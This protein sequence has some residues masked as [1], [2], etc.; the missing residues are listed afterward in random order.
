MFNALLL[1]PCVN[2]TII[3]VLL[4]LKLVPGEWERA[5][6]LVLLITKPASA[7]STLTSATAPATA[8]RT[9][10]ASSSR[11]SLLANWF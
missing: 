8:M 9:T 3:G 1:L 11:P 5:P 7:I 2:G 10:V 6:E 4:S